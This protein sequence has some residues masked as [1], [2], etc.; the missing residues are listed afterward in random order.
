MTENEVLYVATRAEQRERGLGLTR[1]QVLKL[2]AALPVVAGLARVGPAAA[3]R[4]ATRADSPIVKPLP[5]EWFIKF[6][7]NAEMRWDAIRVSDTRRRTSASSS[8]TTPR[9]RSSMPRPGGCACSAAGCGATALVHLR[10]T[11]PAA[12]A[13]EHGVHRVR[14]QRAQLLRRQQG[15]PAPGTQWGLGAIG[16]AQLA[17]RSVVRGARAGRD[18]AQ[19]GRRHARG[20]RLER[21]HRRRRLRPRPPA[22]PVAK[23]LD[24][25]LLAYEMN[26]EPLP[27]DHG[28]PLRL[29]V[30]G[31][32]GIANVK[33]VGQIE[34]SDQPLFSPWN[35]KQYRLTG[36]DY[37]A[38]SPPLTTQVVKRAW[39]LAVRRGLPYRKHG[40]VTGR[41]WSGTSAIKSGR[42]QHRPGCD[43]AARPGCGDRTL[44]ARGH[45][46][47][48]TS[49]R[50]ARAPTSSGRAR[51]TR[52][53]WLSR[54]L[55]RS[56]RTDT[57]SVPWCGTPS[58][59]A[60]NPR[61]FPGRATTP[62]PTVRT[63]AFSRVVPAARHHPARAR[64]PDKENHENSHAH[65]ARRARAR[66]RP[67]RRCRLGD[68]PCR[69]QP[70]TRRA[71]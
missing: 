26:G 54:R 3:A 33:W 32:V 23:A 51:R 24:D 10:A 53:A 35:T 12:L 1:A 63:G 2:G 41:A 62:S 44:P 11:A 56:T 8:A 6:G 4:A 25:V 40:T 64:S 7:T 70:S 18:P 22:V 20:A 29:V 45:A 48:S 5:P 39:E 34:V 42:R 71:S 37:P 47:T 43:V 16:V 60:D 30:P 36:A 68:D 52:T 46:G 59:C 55:R 14:R 13:H 69:Q 19:C 67:G 9:R 38:D 57:S 58:S 31:W 61:D 50:N 66:R 49:P 65:H 28:F 27:P 17:R 15:T 21:G